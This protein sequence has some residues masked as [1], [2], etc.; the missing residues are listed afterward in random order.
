MQFYSR[1]LIKATSVHARQ[2]LWGK[3]LVD[4]V[5]EWEMHHGWRQLWIWRSELWIYECVQRHDWMMIPPD[6]FLTPPQMFGLFCCMYDS[7]CSLSIWRGSTKDKNESIYP[8]FD[9]LTSSFWASASIDDESVR[10]V[11]TES[12]CVPSA[13]YI[14]IARKLVV[15]Q[16]SLYQTTCMRPR[17]APYVNLHSASQTFSSSSFFGWTLLMLN[18]GHGLRACYPVWWIVR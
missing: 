7:K 3:Q 8:I 13:F 17:V 6:L 16:I 4:G 1:T 10:G 12:G 5:S 14:N 11:S 9:I 18:L 15:S 2:D